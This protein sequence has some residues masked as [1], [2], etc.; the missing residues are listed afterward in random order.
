M[1]VIDVNNTFVAKDC[2][3]TAFV[4]PETIDGAAVSGVQIHA[5]LIDAGTAAGSY[6]GAGELVVTDVSGRVLTVATAIKAVPEITIHQRSFNSENHF[7]G[8]VIKG[9]SITSYHLT[10]YKAPV[11]HV[12]V[13]SGID[14][15]LLD[16]EYM[17]KVRRI[18]TDN[19]K[20]KQTTVKTAY[21][22][23]ALAGSTAIQIATGLVAYINANFNTDPLVP[24]IATLTGTDEVT[25]QALPYEFEPGKFRYAKLNFVVELV[26]FVA[27]VTSNDKGQITV[28]DTHEQATKG[29]GTYQQV[30]EMEAFGKLYTGAN[31]NVQSPTFKRNIVDSETQLA[32]TYDTLVINW[33]NAQGDFSQNVVQK[34]SLTLFLPV[35]NNATNQVGSTTIGAEGIVPVLDQYVVTEY[36]VGIA[37]IGNIT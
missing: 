37:Q 16:H 3:R 2:D 8:P 18:G 24:I 23:S 19:N 4:G 21:F 28:T 27:T 9:G 22:H 25:I 20:I 31:K 1:D 14:A 33:K 13:I 30:I 36:G 35:T 17:I 15:S 32:E 26:N 12:S 11:E 6:Y 7:T 34:G 5:P 29:A 10:P